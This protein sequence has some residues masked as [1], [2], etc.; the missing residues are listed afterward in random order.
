MKTQKVWIR[1]MVVVWFVVLGSNS[2]ARQSAGVV[3][4][5]ATSAP[6]VQTG[7]VC[8][9]AMARDRSRAWPRSS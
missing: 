4:P 9:A 7:S 6:I 8:P 1:A 5:D 2:H 3:R